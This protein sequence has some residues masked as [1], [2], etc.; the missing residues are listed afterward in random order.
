MGTNRYFTLFVTS[1]EIAP[2]LQMNFQNMV[3]QRR[4]RNLEW[5]GLYTTTSVSRDGLKFGWV[6]ERVT[7][8]P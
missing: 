6:G 4:P 3:K 2:S 8:Y 5:N 1:S 7:T